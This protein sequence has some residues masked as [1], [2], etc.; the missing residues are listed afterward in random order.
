[1]KDGEGIRRKS[2]RR[3]GTWWREGCR[4]GEDVVLWPCVR[5][6]IF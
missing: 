5:Y 1:M 2:L 3:L 6:L 4:V